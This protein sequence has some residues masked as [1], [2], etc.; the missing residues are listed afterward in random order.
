MNNIE[1]VFENEN[2]AVINK[3]VGLVVNRSETT[4]G[5]TLQDF[6]EENVLN[7]EDFNPESEFYSRSG[8]VHRLD[9]DTSG[10]LVV[11]KN[12]EYF[13]YL[14]EKFRTREVEKKYLVMTFNKVIDERF[15]IDAPL[16]RNP[17]NRF[18]YAIVRDGKDAQTY[19]EKIK[20]VVINDREFSFLYA[21]PRTG[22][23]HQIR[24]HLAANSTPVA[25]D[26][27]YLS[28]REQEICNSCTITRMMLHS[29]SLKFL[30]ID[31]EEFYFEAEIPEEFIRL[32]E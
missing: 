12:E 28:E 4:K 18:K 26:V 25:G 2:F 7:I 16:A 13:D 32:M 29:L 23:T 22:R 8:I 27:I 14:Q 20:D 15:E 10:L 5:P 21:Q 6:L 30:G 19:F 3:P 11:A 17:K 9:K 31:G 24:V 1:I